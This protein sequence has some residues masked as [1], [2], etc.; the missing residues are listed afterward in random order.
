VLLFGLI[1]DN[2]NTKFSNL[3]GFPLIYHKHLCFHSLPILLSTPAMTL[4]AVCFRS[5]SDQV[6]VNVHSAETNI[7]NHVTHRGAAGDTRVAT[8]VTDASTGDATIE[9][10]DSHDHG[11]GASDSHGQ[12]IV[13]LD[14]QIMSCVMLLIA[15]LLLL[16]AFAVTMK[17]PDPP[18]VPINLLKA[19][20]IT[21]KVLYL[22]GTF[23][24][25]FALCGAQEVSVAYALIQRTFLWASVPLAVVVV[26]LKVAISIISQ[27]HK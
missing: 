8:N 2:Y 19:I 6:V 23:L 21:S 13:D 3:S 20:Y 22:W 1:I 11:H 7:S 24:L 4:V 9:T 25:L 14:I 17:L 18:S 16:I 10:S 27:I 5:M 15:F 26:S 12:A